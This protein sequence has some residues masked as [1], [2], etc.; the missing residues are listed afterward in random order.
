MLELRAV[1]KAF[2]IVRALEDVTLDVAR[3]EFLRIL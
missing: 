2:G 3:G 1:R